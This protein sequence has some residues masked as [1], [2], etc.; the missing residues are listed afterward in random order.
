MPQREQEVARPQAVTDEGAM[1]AQGGWMV[2]G[3]GSRV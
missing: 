3:I 1:T 2:N